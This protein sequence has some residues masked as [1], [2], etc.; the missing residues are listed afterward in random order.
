[1]YVLEIQIRSKIS[2]KTLKLSI[3]SSRVNCLFSAFR[4]AEVEFSRLLTPIRD[5][6][7]LILDV[8]ESRIFVNYISSERFSA[9]RAQFIRVRVTCG[10][11]LSSTCQTRLISVGGRNAQ[12]GH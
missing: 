9:P 4:R 7:G 12:D 6:Q 3:R 8:G 5:E 10:H 2:I 1:M 11:F